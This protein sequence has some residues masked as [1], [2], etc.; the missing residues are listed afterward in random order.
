MEISRTNP[1]RVFYDT[2]TLIALALSS[3]FA[4]MAGVTLIMPLLNSAS[5]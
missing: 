2:G 5:L 3:A 1:Q 4:D